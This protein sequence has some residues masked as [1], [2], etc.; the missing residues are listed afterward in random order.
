[1][2]KISEITQK[3]GYKMPAKKITE[4][5]ERHHSVDVAASS[6]MANYIKAPLLA[7]D[8]QGEREN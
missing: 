6:A 4:I 3:K 5:Y 1:L 7:E 8:L 2:G